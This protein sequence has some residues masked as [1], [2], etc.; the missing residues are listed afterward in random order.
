[1]RLIESVVLGVVQGLTEFL[2]VSS[3]AHLLLVPA[4]LKWQE[5]SVWFIVALHIGTLAACLVYFRQDVFQLAVS[6]FTSLKKMLRVSL[7]TDME[8]LAWMIFASTFVT[9]FLGFLLK[10]SFE[11]LFENMYATAFF[12]LV[13]AAILFLAERLKKEKKTIADV[14]FVHALL[15][16]LG[17]T[18]S[19]T[20]GISRSGSCISSAMFLGYT[21]KD[22]ARYAFLLAVP[23]IL[24]AVVL[25]GHSHI[26][27]IMHR[28]NLA[29]V[30]AGVTASFISGM[31]AIDF[32]MKKIKQIPLYYFSIYCVLF[33]ASSFFILK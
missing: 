33:G 31:L 3:T 25:E 1:M 6:F 11:R 9:A 22:A 4:W 8:K 13:T 19:I 29:V 18:I 15:I 20:P 27:E 28:E 17:Q 32:L 23:A 16:G 26:K 2:P 10:D 7:F 12:L 14:S 5:P 24:G 21:K 30:S